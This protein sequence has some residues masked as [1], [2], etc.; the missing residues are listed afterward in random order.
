MRLGFK[1]ESVAPVSTRRWQDFPLILIL[2]SSWFFKGHTDSSVP[3]NP[4]VLSILEEIYM[5]ALFLEGRN[6]SI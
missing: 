2:V 6:E 5:G 3:E 1:V 4:S